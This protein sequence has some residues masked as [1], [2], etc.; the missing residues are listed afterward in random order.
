MIVFT[1]LQ[2]RGI[3][4][5]LAKQGLFPQP[6]KSGLPSRNPDLTISMYLPDKRGE[7]VQFYLK[8]ISYNKSYFFEID[9]FWFRC[10][11]LRNNR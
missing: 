7:T 3:S 11:I 10:S 2:R 4:R 1:V 6:M 8:H 9:E 5:A